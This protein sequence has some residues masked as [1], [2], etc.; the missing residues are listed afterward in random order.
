MVELP[1]PLPPP[2]WRD[3]LGGLQGVP[4]AWLLAAGTLIALV[5]AVAVGLVVVLTR[6]AGQGPDVALTLPRADTAV[7]PPDSP[8]T[9]TG[10]SLHVHAAGAVTAPGVVT[11]PAGSRVTDVVAAAGGPA[12]D[13]DLDQVNLAAPVNDGERVYIPRRGETA[14]VSGATAGVNAADGVVNINEADL[15]TLETL[16]G[17][18]PS[19]AQAILDYRKEHGRFRSVDELLNVRGI[20]PSKLSQIKSRARV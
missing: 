6:S 8:A 13:A 3:R 10:A 11:V 2:S 20:G 9:T 5:L 4:T 12:P 16:P 15:A 19:T 18:G 17:V 7:A 14:A 1:R